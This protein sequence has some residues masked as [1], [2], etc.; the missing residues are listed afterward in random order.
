MKKI[1]LGFIG[2][3]KHGARHAE[4]ARELADDFEITAAYDTNPAAAVSVNGGVLDAWADSAIGL[5]MRNDV[6][7]VVIAT[8]PRF[9]VADMSLAIAHGKH[10]L[11][12]KPLWETSISAQKASRVLAEAKKKGL[13]VTS[14]HPRRYDPLYFYA[15]EQMESWCEEMG[16]LVSFNFRFSYHRP[17]E[18][19]RATDSLLMDHLNHEI[20][21]L[22][23]LCGDHQ[24][25][26]LTKVRDG[27]DRY[28]VVGETAL[29][30]NIAF[31]GLRRLES[32]VYCNELE[33]VFR[34]GRVRAVGDLIS[35]AVHN[36][37]TEYN[38]MCD[39]YRPRT[40]FLG[41][42]PALFQ[43]RK[44]MKNFARSIR[45]EEPNYLTHDEM[46]RNTIVCTALVETGSYASF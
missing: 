10:V 1:R 14:C 23:F 13:V 32:R 11:C 40:A 9:H 6:D 12:E 16:R 36:S 20:D 22:H 2:C 35:G 28:D 46:I 29:G 4:V 44:I 45:G 15:K 31:S 26:R 42:E 24:K 5:I 18:G 43:L 37:V 41:I 25:M 38:F 34:D 39:E 33:L 19:W 30:I 27:F 17:S 7:A 8:P 3:G 21:L